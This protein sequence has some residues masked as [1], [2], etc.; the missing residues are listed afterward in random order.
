MKIAQLFP[1]LL[2]TLGRAASPEAGFVRTLKQLVSL[3]GATSGGLCFVPARGT[4][5]VVTTGNRRGSALDLWIRARLDEPV[6]G[7]R[8]DEVAA[9]PDGEARSR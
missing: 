6:R 5:L 8:L 9:P 7:M 3:S 1:V 4:P 2:A